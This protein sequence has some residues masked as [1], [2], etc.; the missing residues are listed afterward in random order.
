[1]TKRRAAA[2]QVAAAKSAAES[3]L[4]GQQQAVGQIAAQGES[5]VGERASVGHTTVKLETARQAGLERAR[6]FTWDATARATAESYERA[7]A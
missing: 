3:R 5:W 6:R 4:A 1:V 2:R 7:L